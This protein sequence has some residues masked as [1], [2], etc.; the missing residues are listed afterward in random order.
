MKQ[1]RITRQYVSHV[2][3]QLTLDLKD[4]AEYNYDVQVLA[5]EL[6]DELLALKTKD[7]VEI[8]ASLTGSVGGILERLNTEISKNNDLSENNKNI[9]ELLRKEAEKSTHYETRYKTE[10]TNNATLSTQWEE[11]ETKIR[12]REEELT[13]EIA[14]LTKVIAEMRVKLA[15]KPAVESSA[16][17]NIQQNTVVQETESDVSTQ[18]LQQPGN[19]ST[20]RRVSDAESCDG[21]PL[22]IT[23]NN[24]KED[25]F[26]SDIPVVVNVVNNGEAPGKKKISLDLQSEFSQLIDMEVG[27]AD[28]SHLSEIIAQPMMQVPV[29]RNQDQVSR[30]N[31]DEIIVLEAQEQSPPPNVGNGP[32]PVNLFIVGD[33][34]TREMGNVVRKCMNNPERRI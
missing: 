25:G 34:H 6:F 22:I 1:V 12:E 11:N 14:N 27:V 5:C 15:E 16:V 33:S 28:K 13:R 8:P 30:E 20:P 17:G 19:L 10:L 32:G 7:V 31:H 18:P 23:P 21:S 26:N 2:E 9:K 4:L 3:Q 29:S 24:D